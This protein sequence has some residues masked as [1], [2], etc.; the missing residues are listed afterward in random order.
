MGIKKGLAIFPGAILAVTAFA[1]S[2]CGGGE[3]IVERTVVVERPVEVTKV[4]QQTVI[5][6]KEKT[7]QQTVLVEKP[8]VVTATPVPTVATNVAPAPKNRASQITFALQTVGKGSGLN[9]TQ[10]G[11][12]Y[13]GV[14][15]TAFMTERDKGVM[16][17]LV[18]SWELSGDQKKL[19]WRLQSGVQF[20]KGVGEMTADDVAW[21]LNDTNAK[22]N[23]TSIASSAGDL[24]A[25]FGAATAIDKST[26]EIAVNKYDVQWDSNQ[27]NAESIAFSVFSKTAFDKN[28]LDWMKKNIIGTGPF[29]I[30]E[31]LDDQRIVVKAVPSHWRETA[32]V[33][34]IT[35]IQVPEDASRKAMLL[36]GE[37]DAAIVPIREEASLIQRGFKIQASGYQDELPVNFGG[38]YWEETNAI[39]GAPLEPWNLASYAKD[40]PWVGAPTSWASKLK[41]EDKNNPAGMDDM[42]QARL[43]RQGLGYAIDRALINEKIFNG[44]GVPYYVNMFATLDAN[45]Q[46]KWVIPYDTKKAEALLDQA[47]FKKDSAGKRM[48]VTLFGASSNSNWSD[49]VEAIAGM[50]KSIGVFTTVVKSD[51]SI[52]RPTVVDRSNT[53]IFVQSCRHNRGQPY[54]W[55]RGHQGTSLTRGGFGCGVEIPTILDYINKVNGELDRVKRVELNK[56]LGDWMLENVPAVGIVAL[57]SNVVYNPKSIESWNM[58]KGFEAKYSAPERIIPAKR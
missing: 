44:S 25:M 5:V 58:R 42:E 3:T 8:V 32:K 18:K 4:V 15:E 57:S 27:L 37:A 24:G 9:S 14:T 31:F 23:P 1:I 2:A 12:I 52:F 56:Q 33:E 54:D 19:T 28:G 10:G 41:Y 55:P 16:P 40:Y 21:S 45:F 48:D 38:N 13:L 34:Q 20:H 7:V 11:A 22:T 47:G 51:Y 6:E 36:T 46:Q 29:E 53:Y 17:M 26:V 49:P 39:T 43:V 30:V 50:W 35:V